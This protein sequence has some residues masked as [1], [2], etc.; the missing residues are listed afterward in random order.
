MRRAMAETRGRTTTK[1]ERTGF[2]LIEIMLVVAI[3][4]LL[5]AIAVPSFMKARAHA[6]RNACINNL[7]QLDAGKDEYALEYGVSVGDSVSWSNVGLYVKNITNRMLCPSGSSATRNYSNSYTI[8]VIGTV[9][10][11]KI[12]P[13]STTHPDHS[14]WYKPN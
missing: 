1:T 12:T 13:G 6:R 8:N 14:V 4:G 7:R 9:P 10:V 3:I 11:C 2:T 5:A